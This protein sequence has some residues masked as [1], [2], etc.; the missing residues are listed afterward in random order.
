MQCVKSQRFSHLFW[1]LLNK[2]I[3][4]IMTARLFFRIDSNPFSVCAGKLEVDHCDFLFCWCIFLE[5]GTQNW[6]ICGWFYLGQYFALGSVVWFCVS[7]N[8]FSFFFY[9]CSVFLRLQ[10]T[11]SQI[12]AGYWNTRNIQT[13]SRFYKFCLKYKFFSRR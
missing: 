9:S 6:F 7:N 13:D 2:I 3:N 12:G 11:D 5:S 10:W 1:Y 8:E 4:Y